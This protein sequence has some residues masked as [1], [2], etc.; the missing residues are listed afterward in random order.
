VIVV[1]ASAV[2]D[3]LI[4]NGERGNWARAEVAGADVLHAPHL[5]DY[6]T[7]AATRR[8]V[9]ARSISAQRGK[10][11][12]DDLEALPIQRYLAEPF[13]WRVWTLRHSVSGS[14]AFY[15]ALAEALDCPLVTTDGRLARSHGHDAV[16]RSP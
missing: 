13:V 5:V 11:A 1:D 4:D 3:L 7:V 15:I 6:E 16:V 2:V 8:K 12:L 10:Q 9:L 14:D